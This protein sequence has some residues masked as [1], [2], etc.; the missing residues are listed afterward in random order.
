ML[1]KLWLLKPINK[2]VPWPENAPIFALAF[3]LNENEAREVSA[4]KGDI[5]WLDSYHSSCTNIDDF[6]PKLL[7]QAYGADFE[8]YNTVVDAKPVSDNN[9]SSLDEDLIEQTIYYII[10]RC[11]SLTDKDMA[12][13]L[14]LC[15]KEYKLRY[16]KTKTGLKWVRANGGPYCRDIIKIVDQL[17]LNSFIVINDTL[18]LGSRS[19]WNVN[20]YKLSLIWISIIKQ[21]LLK[22]AQSNK[23]YINKKNMV[24][25]IYSL[26]DFVKADMNDELL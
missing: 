15:D 4:R 25:Y 20:E 17:S 18:N 22:F 8:I 3:A 13:I 26:P 9:S 24:E 23:I 21:I 5:V 6:E 12:Q 16:N 14:Y 1:N 19:F 11:E 10:E 7:A 2:N